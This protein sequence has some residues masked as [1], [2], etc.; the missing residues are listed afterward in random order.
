MKIQKLFKKVSS[1]HI[2]T[3]HFTSWLF[4]DIFWC[5]KLKWLA[6][7]MIVPTI[8]LTLHILYVEKENRDSNITLLSWVMM[9]VFWM[10]HE[11]HNIPMWGV[12]ISIGFGVINTL[13]LILQSSSR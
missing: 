3:I 4:K 11:L 13:R 1:K 12:Y 6:T 7:F 2:Q 8:L 9:N 5:L 10:S